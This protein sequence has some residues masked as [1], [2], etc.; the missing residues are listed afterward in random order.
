M[1]GHRIG[2]GPFAFDSGTST[3]WRDGALVPLGRRAA[4]ILLALLESGGGVVGKET[5]MERG[6]PGAIVEESN[7][8]VQVATLRKILGARPGGTEWIATVPRVGYRLVREPPPV[9]QLVALPAI[10]PALAVLPFVNMSDDPNTE[11]FADGLVEDLITAFSRF[12]SFAV[13]ARQSTFAFRHSPLDIREI[14]TALGVRYVLEGSV[15]RVGRDVR[16]TAQ[17]IDGETGAHIWAD[18]LDG[19]IDD[20]F[21]FQDRVTSRVV[22]MLE[23]QIRRSEI[24][25]ARRK[26]PG[27]LDAYD[28][29]LRALPLI[30]SA[31]DHEFDSYNRAIELFDRS[32]ALDESFAPAL[33]HAAWAHEKRLTRGGTAPAG[34]DDAERAITLSEQAMIADPNDP[35][36]LLVA[37]VVLV[38]IRKEPERG[39]ALVKRAA[40]LNPNSQI[41]A[42][43]A[44][45]IHWFRGNYED[46]IAAHLRSLSLA[47]GIP[48]SA[49]SLSGL[50]RAQL[51]AGRIEDAL[52]TALRGMEF[53]NPR[54]FTRCVVAACYALLDRQDEAE[55]AVASI[56]KTSPTLTTGNLFGTHGQLPGDRPLVEGLLRAGLPAA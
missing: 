6:W 33:A 19:T 37:G 17:L 15:R 54:V 7:L 44:A 1:S 27:N 20:V 52:A 43:T 56:R 34:V 51:S 23:P 55:A 42:T 8:V 24:D 32:I 48:E 38:T 47:P 2:F 4:A 39:H 49:W 36:A 13:V 11:H 21:A 53:D 22:G 45:Y 26:P 12:T 14:A 9:S 50:S 28:L 46:S 40:A 31:G 3:L 10:R 16:I 41:I 29:F 30:Q 25:R 35:L 18:K 5:L